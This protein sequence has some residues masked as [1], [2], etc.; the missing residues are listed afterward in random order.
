MEV[1]RSRKERGSRQFALPVEV[2]G[3]RRK[4]GRKNERQIKRTNTS[5]DGE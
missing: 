5:T 2:L 1:R 3:I 4:K